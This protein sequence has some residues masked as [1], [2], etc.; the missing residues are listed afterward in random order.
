MT[1]IIPTYNE[2]YKLTYSTE[3]AKV[4]CEIIYTLYGGI[5]CVSGCI[6]SGGNSADQNTVMVSEVV[7]ICGALVGGQASSVL[8]VNGKNTLKLMLVAL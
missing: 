6:S 1:R 5:D 2:Q 4:N 7:T 8:I 3:V